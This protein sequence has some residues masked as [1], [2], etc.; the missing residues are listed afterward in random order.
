MSNL[1][2][3]HP[4]RTQHHRRAFD[5][6][7]FVRDQRGATM[8][9]FA[10]ALP[11]M[12]GA[13]GV[14]IDYGQMTVAK[15][16]LQGAADAAATAAARELHLANTDNSLAQSVAES[17]VKANLGD[18]GA[19]VRVATRVIPDPVAVRVELSQDVGMFIMSHAIGTPTIS[20]HAVARLVGGTPICVLAL[21]KSQRNA[22]SLLNSA[23][24]TGDSCAVY[25]NSTSSSGVRA[26][27]SAT[28][29]TELTCTAGGFVGTS[30]NYLPMPLTDCPEI[31]DPLADRPAP[32]VGSCIA[33]E[34]E[35]TSGT[36]TLSPGTYCDG[37]T[38]TGTA[39]VTLR[40][41]I[42]VIK[43]E[44]LEI[45]GMAQLAGK[46]VGFYLTGEDATF[47]FTPKTTIDLSAP[48]SGPLAG[49]L[50][51]EDRNAP[52]GRVHT[53]RSDDAR[54]LIGTFY[55]PR[56]RLQVDATKPVA[57]E[58]AYTA[59]IANRLQLFSGPNLV[60]NTDYDQ[61][62]VP[63]PDGIGNARSIVLAQ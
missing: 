45:S 12:I 59:I 60:L 24:L 6:I 38:I 16:R 14:A 49:L 56:G 34:L 25:S 28:M 15:A 42:Y 29:K 4:R 2:T 22:V 18:A 10:L 33:N 32:T 50:F 27:N 53:I 48:V 41:G 47:M 46:G 7:R 17:V 58:S 5:P 1:N 9:L 44:R 21:E 61:T 8:L 51:F 11:V 63:V 19:G 26:I 36:T 62:D 55:L 39:N 31:E 37:L 3:E 40:P 13:V 52:S 30:S 20:T 54:T 35:I 57:D 23:R 43:G